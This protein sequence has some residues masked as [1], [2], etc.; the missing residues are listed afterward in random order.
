MTKAGWTARALARLTGIP[1]ATVASWVNIGLV[2]PDQRGR[3]RAGHVIGVTGL[4]E[5]LAIAELRNHGFSLQSIRQAVENLRR[6]TGRPR[7]LV[8]LVLVASGG[9]I[10]WRDASE[11]DSMPVSAL[12]APGQRFLMLPLGLQHAEMLKHLA[13]LEKDSAYVS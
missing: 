13:A 10:V 5:I 11:I 9:D 7:P 8:S 2:V 3:G 12:A 4:L 6:L 1:P